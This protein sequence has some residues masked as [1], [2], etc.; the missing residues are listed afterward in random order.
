M[1]RDNLFGFL[2]AGYFIKRRT[3]RHPIILLPLTFSLQI[4]DSSNCYILWNKEWYVFHFFSNNF[5]WFPSC[6]SGL[7]APL[8]RTPLFVEYTNK[9]TPTAKVL[10]ITQI[11]FQMQQKKSQ[12]HLPAFERTRCSQ[13]ES[14]GKRYNEATI[15]FARV[16]TEAAKALLVPNPSCL[17]KLTVCIQISDSVVAFKYKRTSDHQLNK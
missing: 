14:D 9:S 8:T 4:I 3:G 7:L 10:L 15:R 17:N 13:F 16:K 2:L 11:E 1:F 12:A 5:H 6:S